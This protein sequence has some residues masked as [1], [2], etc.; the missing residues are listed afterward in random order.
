MNGYTKSYENFLNTECKIIFK[1]NVDKNSKEITY[2]D[3]T[4]PEKVRLFEKM[5]I[6]SQFPALCKAKEIGQ[7]WTDFFH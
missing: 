6:A 2:Q 1:W 3:L 5:D 7:F 4:G